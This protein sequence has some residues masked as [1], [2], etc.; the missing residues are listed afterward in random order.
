VSVAPPV[1]HPARHESIDE[2]D[3]AVVPDL[4]PLG[5]GTDGGRP[6]SLEAFQLQQQ[7]VLLR[8]DPRRPG[9]VLASTEE[10]A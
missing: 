7:R 2:L 3:G 10:T 9:H 4:K 6:P 1:H 5:E 8:L